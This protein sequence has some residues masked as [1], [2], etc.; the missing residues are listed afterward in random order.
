VPI[1]RVDAVAVSTKAPRRTRG[2]RLAGRARV[3]VVGA[4]LVAGTVVAGLVI[5][6]GSTTPSRGPAS[7]TTGSGTTAVQ[8][9][10]LVETDTESGTLSYAASHTVYNRLSGT[11]TWL[12]GVGQL[13]KRG[14]ALFRVD[15]KPVILLYGSTPAYRDLDSSDS[16]GPDI[17][18]LNANLVALGYNPDGIVVD[19]TWQTATTAGVETFQKALGETENGKLPLGRVV[20]LPGKQLV[21][22]LDGTVGSG[23]GGSGSGSSTAGY[24]PADAPS[25]EFVSYHGS[26]TGTTGRT[27]A[28]ATTPTTTTSTSTTSTTPPRTPPG[29]RPTHREG[30]GGGTSIASLEALIARLERQ[31]AALSGHSGSGSPGGSSSDSRGGSSSGSSG[32][33]SSSGNS[34]NSSSSG[35]AGSSGRNGGSPVAILQTSSTRLVATVDLAAS[36]QSEAVVGSHVTVELPNGPTVGGTIT[37]VSPV[38]S[39]SS[40]G[41]GSGSSG[42]GSGSSGSGGSGSSAT[43]PVTITLDQRVKAGGLDQ[44]SVS[45]NFAQARARNVLSVPVTAL[46]A[47]AGGGYAV[48]QAA[49][50]HR[51]IPV[52]TGLFT[53]GYVQISGPAVY[54]GLLVTDSQG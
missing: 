16:S 37:A 43:V 5:S 14:Q 26:S 22:S 23:S 31:I 32:G 53:A 25:P 34:S 24:I 18:E 42:S 1:E 50:P 10:N 9:R 7:S 11:I 3:V 30:G 19:D 33:S 46:L 45:V 49:A 17:R 6:A 40:S 39:N 51:L 47:T 2:R 15:N 54:P 35:G 28:T 13:I 48:Q 21:N 8:R 20:F 29:H 27:G 44:A 12:P 36:S 38:A 52:T 41:S 4:L